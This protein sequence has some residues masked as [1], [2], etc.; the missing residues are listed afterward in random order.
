MAI[1]YKYVSDEYTTSTS[2][3]SRFSYSTIG[4]AGGICYYH[5]RGPNMLRFSSTYPRFK[6]LVITREIYP[7]GY[8][9]EGIYW[10]VVDK[11]RKSVV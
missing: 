4:M 6:I 11:D 9:K 8:R 2:A 10:Y 1:S 7:V 5:Q 3:N